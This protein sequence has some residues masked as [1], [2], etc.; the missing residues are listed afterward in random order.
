M[1]V[2]LVM[3]VSIR[4]YMWIHL[5][6]RVKS[7]AI[8]DYTTQQHKRIVNAAAL[9][10]IRFVIQK[11]VTRVVLKDILQVTTLSELARQYTMHYKMRSLKQKLHLEWTSN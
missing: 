2:I 10:R 4:H 5:R 6:V 3:L 11:V 8:V 7:S 1:R 9:L